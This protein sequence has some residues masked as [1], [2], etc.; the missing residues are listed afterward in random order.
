MQQ[1]NLYMGG[2]NEEQRI[3]LLS[4]VELDRPYVSP[5]ALSLLKRDNPDLV[6]NEAIYDVPQISARKVKKE[7]EKFLRHHKNTQQLYPKMA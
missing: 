1:E 4:I 5:I 6:F 3:S 2:L 7:E